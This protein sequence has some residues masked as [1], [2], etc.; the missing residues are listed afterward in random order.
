MVSSRQPPKFEKTD[1]QH[2][3]NPF[4]EDFITPGALSML[5]WELQLL[6]NFKSS[7]DTLL[8]ASK[9]P[10]AH[11][12]RAKFGSPKEVLVTKKFHPRQQAAEF[13]NE[14]VFPILIR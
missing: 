2:L 3:Q 1:E 8:L 10:V 12:L 11:G 14:Y 7:N 9:T 6:D 13:G 4:S 5:T